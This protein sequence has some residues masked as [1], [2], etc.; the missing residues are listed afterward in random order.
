MYFGVAK[1]FLVSRIWDKIVVWQ[2]EYFPIRF[3]LVRFGIL[4]LFEACWL[5]SYGKGCGCFR[6]TVFFLSLFYWT[7]LEDGES[8]L[9]MIFVKAEWI[10][11][12]L[13]NIWLNCQDLRKKVWRVYCWWCTRWFATEFS[14]RSHQLK[15]DWKIIGG[16]DIDR[17]GMN[18]FCVKYI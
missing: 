18:Q 11:C 3:D 10:T 2:W 9:G 15:G 14:M 4:L 8:E 13:S 7:I 17:V 5:Q 16:K 1:I 12:F 6:W